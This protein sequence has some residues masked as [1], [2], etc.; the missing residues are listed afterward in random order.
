MRIKGS[1]PGNAGSMKCKELVEWL[2][3][4]QLL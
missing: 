3:D 2:S 1:D 4:W